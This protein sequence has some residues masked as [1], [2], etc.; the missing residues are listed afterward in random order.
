MKETDYDLSAF[1]A[2]QNETE[3]IFNIP[4][5]PFR[6]QFQRD[7]DRVLYSKEFRRLSGKTQV[8]VA[9][10]YDDMRTRLTHT[11]EV[12][13]IAETISQLLQ[14]DTMLTTAIA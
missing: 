5:H 10:F 2:K 7:R 1:K 4:P 9:G 6:S 14:L 11:L 12:V 3:R 13:Q 8:F